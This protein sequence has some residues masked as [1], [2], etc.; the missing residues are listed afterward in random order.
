MPFGDLGV[1]RAQ[2]VLK[3]TSAAAP[4]FF[5]VAPVRPMISLAALV[6]SRIAASPPATF[7][8]ILLRIHGMDIRHQ[9]KRGY[10]KW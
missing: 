5:A 3:H 7:S 10:A 2:Y 9:H 6:L 8:L 1:S 4:P